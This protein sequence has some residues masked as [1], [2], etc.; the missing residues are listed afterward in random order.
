MSDET[1]KTAA[2]KSPLVASSAPEVTAAARGTPDAPQ[3][4]DLESSILSLTGGLDMLPEAEDAAQDEHSEPVEAPRAA[5]SATAAASPI[6][7]AALGVG[8]MVRGVAYCAGG[9]NDD[10]RRLD[11]YF[12]GG[13]DEPANAEAAM[14]RP[15]VIHVHGGGWVRGDRSIGFYGAP[16][17][18][19]GYAHKGFVA[20]A[21]S[22]RLGQYPT[23]LL[24]V[25]TAIVFATTPGNLERA[26]RTESSVK[27]VHLEVLAA[28]LKNGIVLSGHSAGAHIVSTITTVGSK[29]GCLQP[30]AQSAL[31]TAL[32]Q[33]LTPSYVKAVML[34]SGIY[35]LR[36]PFS[37]CG[38]C[39]W[40]NSVFNKIYIEK[41]FKP[42]GADLDE[43]SPAWHFAQY[44]KADDSPAVSA[45]CKSVGLASLASLSGGDGEH[46]GGEP[47]LLRIPCA[48]FS[49]ACDLGL[50]QDAERFANLIVAARRC[51][52]SRRSGAT[53]EKLDVGVSRIVIP[54]TG[55][56][57]ICTRAEAHS[58]FGDT[59]RRLLNPLPNA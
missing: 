36:N 13:L 42:F 5:A 2:L 33:L 39:N 53:D 20:V 6:T 9:Q 27:A 18:A 31:R 52:M 32:E 51:A 28:Q 8:T 10:K 55:H 34:L 38:P 54:K 50:E 19:N 49:A 46:S 14:R 58:T 30:Q 22:Y 17:M 11:I 23:F 59:L 37:G 48:V 3:D 12:P 21:P 56:P 26:A 47:P 25:I 24:D 45:F 35:T 43:L 44:T 15:L 1:G 41:A 16:A 29:L 7:V 57:T 40:K 4:L